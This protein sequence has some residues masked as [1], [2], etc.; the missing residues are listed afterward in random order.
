MKQSL[1]RTPRKQQQHIQSCR[2]RHEILFFQKVAGRKVVDFRG[3][4]KHTTRQEMSGI[5]NEESVSN[6]GG[7][8]KQCCGSRAKTMTTQKTTTQQQ[9]QCKEGSSGTTRKFLE[10]RNMKE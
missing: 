4:K 10:R 1:R 3:T 2:R 5:G 8:F 9:Q 7:K 6:G